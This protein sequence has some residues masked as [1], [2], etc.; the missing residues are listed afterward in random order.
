MPHYVVTAKP[1][2]KLSDLLG[3]L[4]R[5]KYGSMRR[6]GKTLT[7]S[8]RNARVQEDGYAAWEEEGYCTPPLAEERAAALDKLF[9]ELKIVPVPSGAGWEKIK[10]LRPLFPELVSTAQRRAVQHGT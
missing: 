4:R 1:S 7:Y 2:H 5:V 3:N 9:D 10:G 6:F 8:L